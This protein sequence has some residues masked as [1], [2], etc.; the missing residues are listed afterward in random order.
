M[1][2]A[3][4]K[5]EIESEIASRF[6]SAFQVQKTRPAEVI[7]TG[8]PEVDAFALGGL[9]RG[10]LTEI[11]GPAS[12]GRT[13]FMLS[14]LAHATNH[15]EVCALVD[16]HNSF[17]PKSAARAG[18]NSERLL[19]IRCAHN[20]EHAFKAS[21]LLLQGGGF[22]LVLL[23]LGDVPGKSAKRIISSWWYR[24]RRTL[25]P[26]PTALVVIAEES[27]VRSCA[28]LALELRAPTNLWSSST[29]SQSSAS[30][31]NFRN[32]RSRSS[33]PS[34]ASVHHSTTPAPGANKISLPHTTLLQRLTFHVRCHRPLYL[35]RQAGEVICNANC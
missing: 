10:A 23:D 26:T 32:N 20:L 17:D 21:D 28:S 9:P 6:G 35:N 19:W 27:C 13:S 3:F 22:G 16:T 8:I 34:L 14:A 33:Y 4:S 29:Q 1:R 2:A 11:F 24:F 31:D 5:V 15:E 7:S 25:E 18:I 12:S 30:R